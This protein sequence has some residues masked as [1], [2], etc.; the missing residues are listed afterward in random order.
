VCCDVVEEKKGG[1]KTK[2]EFVVPSFKTHTH[3]HTHT[4]LVSRRASQ[5]ALSPYTVADE[6][7][8]IRLPA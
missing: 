2:T 4:C 6:E 5:P 8:T 1:V 3:A 7:N